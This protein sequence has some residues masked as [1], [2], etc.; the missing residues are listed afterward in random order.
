MTYRVAFEPSSRADLRSIARY[1]TRK[2]SAQV[3]RQFT[4]DITAHC[5]SFETFPYRGTA[6]P[7]LFLGARTTG[8]RNTITI[9]FAVSE[10]SRLVTIIAILYGGRS[11][12]ELFV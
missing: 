1:I 12:E 4:R 5:L 3:A 7:E 10:E 8:F 9:L 6:R 2:N 11:L